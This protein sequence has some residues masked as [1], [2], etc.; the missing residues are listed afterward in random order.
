MEKYGLIYE[1]RKIRQ[2]FYIYIYFVCILFFFFFFLFLLL[3][4]KF[5]FIV[6]RVKKSGRTFRFIITIQT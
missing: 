4:L 6:A 1:D 5:K 2:R 3:L